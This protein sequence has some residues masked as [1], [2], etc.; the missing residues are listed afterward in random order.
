MV[1]RRRRTKGRFPLTLSF[2][3]AETFY[4][5]FFVSLMTD[6]GGVFDISAGGGIVGIGYPANTTSSRFLDVNV[7]F[8]REL[9]AYALERCPIGTTSAWIRIL[10]F[11][12]YMPLFLSTGYYIVSPL[13]REIYIAFIGMCMAVDVLINTMLQYLI[14]QSG[15][16]GQCTPQAY[17]MP[18]GNVEQF[19]LVYVL[20]MSYFSIQRIDIGTFLRLAMAISAAAVPVASVRLGISS[21]PQVAVGSLVGAIEACLWQLFAANVLA[22]KMEQFAQWKIVRWLGY[23]DTMWNNKNISDSVSTNQEK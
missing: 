5:I 3:F 2:S 4:P 15:P 6:V 16:Y 10:V 22:N 12:H 8:I 20:L 18:D 23:R 14:R 21:L 11:F 9:E 7:F 13:R 19:T 17:N 1:G